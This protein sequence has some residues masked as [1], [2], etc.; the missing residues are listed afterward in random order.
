MA[1]SLIAKP[2]LVI[3]ILIISSCRTAKQPVGEDIMTDQ[4]QS[5]RKYVTTETIK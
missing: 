4:L 3:L 1:I 5:D 2:A